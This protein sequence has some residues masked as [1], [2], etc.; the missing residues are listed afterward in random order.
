MKLTALEPQFLR[1]IEPGKGYRHVDPD[2]FEEA[3]GVRFTCPKCGDHQVLVWFRDRDVPAQEEPTPRWAVS[4]TG[5]SD[6]TLAP[7]INVRGCWHGFVR[8]GEIR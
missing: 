8:E 7:S 4:G 3:Q 5:I 2:Y 6:L 1:V